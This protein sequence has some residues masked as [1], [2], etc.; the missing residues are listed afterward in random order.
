ML[1]NLLIASLFLL[2]F[3]SSSQETKNQS[4]SLGFG[5]PWNPNI[6]ENKR[7]YNFIINYQNKFAEVFTYEVF[8]Q[9]S[10]ISSFPGFFEN[11]NE[12]DRFITSQEVFEAFRN[13]WWDEINTFSFGGK[14]HYSFVNNSKFFF[15]IYLGAG[16]YNSNSTTA[17][18]N[19]YEAAPNQGLIKEF[20]FTLPEEN[21][22]GLFYMPGIHFNYNVYKDYIIGLDFNLHRNFDN[23]K[24]DQLPVTPS[25][26]G[27]NLSIG[28]KF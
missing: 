19:I 24:T 4:V 22:T 26:Y 7:N 28:K 16:I 3:I 14:I 20:D 18:L 25:F 9:Y 12:L 17:E 11:K 1:R 6:V 2:P 5:L 23:D 15:S 8:A 21:Y 10:M 27:A 13:T